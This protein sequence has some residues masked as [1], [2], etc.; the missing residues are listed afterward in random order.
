M[1]DDVVSPC[2]KSVNFV[3]IAF[4]LH[5]VPCFKGVIAK[6]AVG[7]NVAAGFSGSDCMTFPLA[8]WTLA[9]IVNSAPMTGKASPAS[10]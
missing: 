10:S 9:R 4:Y 7:L 1:V 2:L 5:D 3:L 8:G 6:Q